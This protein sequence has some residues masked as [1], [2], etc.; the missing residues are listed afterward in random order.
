MLLDVGSDCLCMVESDSGTEA[1]APPIGVVSPYESGG[2][3]VTTIPSAV[4]EAVDLDADDELFCRVRDGRI[5]LQK[6]TSLG[7]FSDE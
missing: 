5:E 6:T 4:R 7:R 1:D 2:S 3:L